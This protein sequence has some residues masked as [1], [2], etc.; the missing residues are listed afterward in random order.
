MTDLSLSG[1]QMLDQASAI[2]KQTQELLDQA[3]SSLKARTSQDGRVSPAKLDEHQLVSYELALSWAECSSAGFLIAYAQ[4]LQE[5]APSAADFATRLAGFFCA[6][7][8]TT[9]TSRLRARPADFDL[10][11]SAIN[12]VTGSDPAAAFLQSYEPGER[13]TKRG[14]TPS[15]WVW[16]A[17][18]ADAEPVGAGWQKLH[19]DVGNDIWTDRYSN[20]LDVIAWEKVLWF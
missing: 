5:Q 2:L 19:G 14:A 3:L 6:E 17:K 9:T 12:A 10:D 20:L 4:R 15:E 8:V 18:G 13:E 16:L 1:G 7:A 11:A